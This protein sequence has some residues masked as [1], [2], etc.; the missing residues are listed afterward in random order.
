[1]YL[2]IILYIDGDVTTLLSPCVYTM[3][4][5]SFSEHA[6]LMFQAIVGS[7]SR[8]PAVYSSF[9]DNSLPSDLGTSLKLCLT[10]PSFPVFVGQ[11]EK[12]LKKI[13]QDCP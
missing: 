12:E 7:E 4:E 2:K 5:D 11:V 1:M 13:K 6:K 10:D 8:L 9:H 3:L